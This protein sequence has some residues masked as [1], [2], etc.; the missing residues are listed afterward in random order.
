MH[1]R[2]TV[3]VSVGNLLTSVLAGFVIFSIVG[4]MAKRLDVRVEEV[5]ASGKFVLM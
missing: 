3:I 1:R 5:I 2:D 4:H